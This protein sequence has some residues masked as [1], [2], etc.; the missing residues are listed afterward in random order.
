MILNSVISL[1]TNANIAMALWAQLE[2]TGMLFCYINITKLKVVLISMGDVTVNFKKIIYKYLT[3]SPAS[4][5]VLQEWIKQ[6]VPQVY[7]IC[8]HHMST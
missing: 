2:C 6:I 4:K 7:L 3:L 5:S 8:E 1:A